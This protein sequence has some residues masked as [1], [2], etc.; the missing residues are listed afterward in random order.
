MDHIGLKLRMV[1]SATILFGFYLLV[2]TAMYA[3]LGSL[4]VVVVLSVIF[5]AAQYKFGKW[6]AL[7]SVSAEDMPVSRYPTIHEAA[8][9]LCADMGID[10]PRLMVADMGAPN[11]F[12][13]GRRNAGVVV[14]GSELL[15]VLDKD[16]VEAVLAHELAHLKNR[17]VVMMVLG[18]SIAMLFGWGVYM[19][20]R[21]S[22]RGIGG[23]VLAYAV[24]TLA[25]L[26][27]TLFVLVISRSREYAADSDAAEYTGR[28]DAMVR[29]LQ[30][31]SGQSDS[32]IEQDRAISAMCIFNPHEGLFGR[33]LATHPPVESRISALEAR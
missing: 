15:A 28:P 24:S 5:A 27:V 16:E 23:F 33:L 32:S 8:D 30:K 26:L 3:W 29:A 21:R 9:D 6:L 22:V 4:P 25:N 7:R 12:A 19:I 31:I 2:A 14:L 17:D 10:T 20:V 13:V 11:A 18:Q 1:A